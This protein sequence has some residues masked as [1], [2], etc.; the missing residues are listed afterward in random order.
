MLLPSDLTLTE[1]YNKTT[2]NF[3]IVEPLW[4]PKFTIS[5]SFMDQGLFLQSCSLKACGAHWNF[6]MVI[7]P[8]RSSEEETMC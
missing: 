2:N 1:F 3:R 8:D 7:M 4:V 6:V 5:P